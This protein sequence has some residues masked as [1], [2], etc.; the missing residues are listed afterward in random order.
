MTDQQ[1]VVIEYSHCFSCQCWLDAILDSLFVPFSNFSSSSAA[2]N[3]VYQW[4]EANSRRRCC[5][6]LG[7]D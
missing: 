5:G 1:H 4:C 2:T 6:S 3:M 7:H